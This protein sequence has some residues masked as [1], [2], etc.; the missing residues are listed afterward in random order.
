MLWAPEDCDAGLAGVNE[1]S[2][3]IYGIGN[4][5]R[6]EQVVPQVIPAAPAVILRVRYG[7][8]FEGGVP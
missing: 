1:N 4:V 3:R 8:T 5:M 7:G 2:R 6:R